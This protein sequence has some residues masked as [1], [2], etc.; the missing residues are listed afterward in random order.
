MGLSPLHWWSCEHLRL[1]LSA[2]TL[3]HTL[4]SPHG[5]P[6]T[7]QNANGAFLSSAPQSPQPPHTLSPHCGPHSPDLDL[8]VSSATSSVVI[9]E[10]SLPGH[11]LLGASTPAMLTSVPG[12][13]KMLVPH[14]H[15]ARQAVFMACSSSHF[16]FPQN[17]GLP[18]LLDQTQSP[19]NPCPPLS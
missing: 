8:A 2:P 9:L 1:A 5:S 15:H 14:L 18:G 11:M 7:F 4:C 6:V 3:T 16:V 12:S 10:S 13:L 19:L 17:R